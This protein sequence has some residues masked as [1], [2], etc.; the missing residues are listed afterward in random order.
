MVVSIEVYNN[1]LFDYRFEKFVN[2]TKV[3]NG[4]IL[5]NAVP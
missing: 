5:K 4:E 3:F 2:D 1:R